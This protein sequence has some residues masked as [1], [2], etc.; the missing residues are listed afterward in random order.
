MIALEGV[1]VLLELKSSG[2]GIL[3]KALTI[4]PLP[5]DADLPYQHDVAG[6][7]KVDTTLSRETKHAHCGTSIY[8]YLYI[9][10]TCIYIS[11][12]TAC[13]ITQLSVY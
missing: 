2:C 5:G 4:H 10:G 8:I 13:I 1:L 7:L 11:I 12:I 9:Y 6:N 3:K